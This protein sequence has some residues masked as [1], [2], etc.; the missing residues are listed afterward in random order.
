MT[1]KLAILLIAIITISFY[2]HE[3]VYWKPL[4]P[5][6]LSLAGNIKV[7]YETKMD[8]IWLVQLLNTGSCMDNSV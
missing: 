5:V 3:Q 7:E 6:N 4:Q 1:K 8:E 2:H